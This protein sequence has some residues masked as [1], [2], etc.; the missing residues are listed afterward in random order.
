MGN[1]QRSVYIIQEVDKFLQ[2]CAV[3]G[4]H[5][6]LIVIAAIESAKGMLKLV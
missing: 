4:A 6:V 2:A 3:E 5:T 1:I